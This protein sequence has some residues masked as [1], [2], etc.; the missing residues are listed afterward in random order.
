M[1]DLDSLK[2]GR[3][4]WH[5][6]GFL[7][8]GRAGKAAALPPPRLARHIAPAPGVL[9]LRALLA[10]QPALV[11]PARAEEATRLELLPQ[12][13]R[14]DQGKSMALT[15]LAGRRAVLTMAHADCHKIRPMTIER[16]KQLQKQQGAQGESLDIVIVGYDPQTDDPAAWHHC[17]LHHKLMRP[18]WHFLTGSIKDVFTL[19]KGFAGSVKLATADNSTAQPS[20][21]EKVLKVDAAKY[22]TSWRKKSFRDGANLPPVKGGDA[23]TLAYVKQTP[24]GCNCLSAASRSSASFRQGQAGRCGGRLH[25]PRGNELVARFSFGGVLTDTADQIPERRKRFCMRTSN[26]GHYAKKSLAKD[27]AND[28][29]GHPPK[30]QVRC[31]RAQ[32][33]RQEAPLL[34]EQVTEGE[35]ERAVGCGSGKVQQQECAPSHLAHAGEH[36]DRSGRE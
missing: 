30:D 23:E 14:D 2:R 9:V 24:G 5:R 25:A 13:W 4:S 35:V 26:S 3:A 32:P 19:E 7:P 18:N 22:A 12:R 16:L 17:R 34:A 15:D 11:R 6:P 10:L 28:H 33:P 27:H 36:V 8:V 1:D 20:F 29:E 31:R 21:L